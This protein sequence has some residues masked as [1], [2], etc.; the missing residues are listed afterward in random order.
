MKKTVTFIA[1]A[2]FV[3]AA[4]ISF[5]QIARSDVEWK[6][7]KDLDLK[8]R[9]LD[10]APS[11]DG[12]WLYILTRGEVAI[13]S[14]LEGTITDRISVDKKFD[15]IASLPR[16]DTLV[17]SSARK[18]TLQVVL[19]ERS[20]RIDVAGS[21]F[22]GPQEAPVTIVVFEDYQC[23]YC[24]GLEPLL[25]QVSETYPKDAK[26]VI[27]HFPLAIHG[28][29]KKAAIASLAAGKQGKFW[30]M[31]EKLLANQ[32]DLSDIKVKA[33]VGELSLNVEQFDKDLK[34]PFLAS[35]IEKDTN[36]GIRAGVQG[37][38]T[39]FVNGKP[40]NQRSPEGFRQA[41]EAELKK[42]HPQS[43]QNSR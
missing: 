36:D 8:E 40:F 34:D 22:K 28:Y 1:C 30:E 29:A 16:P 9:P 35:F 4:W 39:I 25:R 2:F 38:P 21:P 6:I 23:P 14:L 31:H 3:L 17:I 24:A 10:I 42:V 37:T 19:L 5:P 7:I 32:R 20:Y 13:Y 33:I 11:L 15:R 41:I 12:K 27:K 43:N 26:L 18:K